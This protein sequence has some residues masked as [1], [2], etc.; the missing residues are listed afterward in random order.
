M[1]R[2]VFVLTTAQS[3][4]SKY[5]VRYVIFSYGCGVTVCVVVCVVV[6]VDVPVVVSVD[7]PDVVM[8]LVPVVVCVLVAV[9]VCVLVPDVVAVLVW[10]EVAVEVWLL[11]G[12]VVWLVVCDV[13]GDVV[14]DVVWLVVGD[15]VC[16]VVLDVVWLVVGVV[17][18]LVVCDVVAVVVCVVVRDVVGDEVGVVVGVVVGDVVLV[19]VW[20]VVGVVD[21]DV[22]L[23]VV[24]VEVG[25]VVRVD[26][27]DVVGEEVC[28]A[29]TGGPAACAADSNCEY[30]DD[31]QKCDIKSNA[32]MAAAG[33]TSGNGAASLKNAYFKVFLDVSQNCDDKLAADECPKDVCAMKANNKCTT[34]I[35]NAFAMMSA[36][37]GGSKGDWAVVR[38]ITVGCQASTA[39]GTCTSQPGC[40]WKDK[41]EDSECD[42]KWNT[43][44][45]IAAL[46]GKGDPDEAIQ[47]GRASCRERV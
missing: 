31:D 29:I 21:C 12:V 9:V 14:G 15:V 16:V 19:V 7:E 42:L 4:L 46:K 30:K 35:P 27:C 37:G 5:P 28:E 13:V 8:V 44:S 41:G 26:V 38:K 18:W 33:I 47:I 22:V 20:L 6:C 3:P 45:I 10:L 25:D 40:R 43:P 17:V 36:V 32:F 24:G 1:S 39:A 2:S 34:N 11:V 23:V